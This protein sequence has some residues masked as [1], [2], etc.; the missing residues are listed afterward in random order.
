[1]RIFLCYPSEERSTAERIRYALAARG[2]D[3]FFDRE[4]LPAGC[5]FDARITEA[6]QE[7]DLFVF[8]IAP[9]SIEQGRY[10]LS[11]LRMAARQWPHPST[12]VLPVLVRPTPRDAIPAYLRA[13]SILEPHGDA[14]AE[15]ADAVDQLVAVHT[16]PRRRRALVATGVLVL[17]AAGVMSRGW[18]TPDAPPAADSAARPSRD[19]LLGEPLPAAVRTR[20][21]GA[22]AAGN[23]Y[24]LALAAPAELQAMTDDHQQLGSPVP[25]PGAPVGIVEMPT[26]YFVMTHAKDA[27]VVIDRQDLSIVMTIPMKVPE[28]AGGRRLSAQVRSA[29]PAGGVLWAITAGD[30]GVTALLKH[31]VVEWQVPSWIAGKYSTGSELPVASCYRLRTVA[32]SVWAVGGSDCAAPASLYRFEG[33]IRV[34][35]FSPSEYPLVACADD[36]AESPAGNLLFLACDGALQEIQLDGKTLRP[37]RTWPRLPVESQAGVRTE[38]LARAGREV[39][40]GITTR[41]DRAD[42]RSSRTHVARSSEDRSVEIGRFPNASLAS[43]AVSPRSVIAVLENGDG[44]FEAVALRRHP[45]PSE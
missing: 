6:L 10:T 17:L 41:G 13:V 32:N 18:L 7:S 26:Q 3:V 25:L 29:A 14:G 5:E 19:P 22:A 27:V 20:A 30:D 44:S 40:I 9:E 45:L 38:V 16:A 43:L 11:E 39:F 23:G 34:D 4:D 42:P 37:L 15:V 36:L 35:E 24:V 12:H 31:R 1:V 33:A 28:A 21:R 8:L 2:H